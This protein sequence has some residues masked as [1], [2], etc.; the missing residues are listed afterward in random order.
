MVELG[1]VIRFM[2]LLFVNTLLD[3]SIMPSGMVIFSYCVSHLTSML[4]SIVQGSRKVKYINYIL[5]LKSGVALSE[6]LSLKVVDIQIN[7]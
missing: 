2:S 6:K 3:I 7:D 5:R 4:F 1:I